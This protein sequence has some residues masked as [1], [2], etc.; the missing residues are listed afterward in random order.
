MKTLKEK[1][2][3]K[4]VG[5]LRAQL[6]SHN[7]GSGALL[8]FPP[9]H[10]DIAH[11]ISQIWLAVS[12]RT[13]TSDFARCGFVH[14]HSVVKEDPKVDDTTDLLTQLQ[15]YGLLDSNVDDVSVLEDVDV[16]VISMDQ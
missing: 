6:A 2:R 3:A 9:Y 15:T 8:M 11:W 10:G 13:I 16:C 14:L 5:N 4:L 12:T 7:C 1:L